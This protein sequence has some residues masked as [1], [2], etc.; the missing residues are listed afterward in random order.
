LA[1]HFNKATGEL[2]GVVYDSKPIYF[3]SG[4]R[5]LAVRRADRRADGTVV[6]KVPKGVDRRYDN[7]AMPGKLT[8]LTSRLDG[9]D[10][11]VEA[12]YIGDLRLARWRISP[13]GTVRLDYEYTFADVVDLIGVNFDYPESAMKS[14]R[15]LGRGPYRVRQNC[16]EG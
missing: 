2:S 12:T 6:E 4:P 10:G 1:L 13:D 5:L 9:A 16:L 7:V 15:W 8:A 11:V 14:I 3:G